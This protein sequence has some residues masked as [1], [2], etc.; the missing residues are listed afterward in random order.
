MVVCIILFFWILP[1]N[2]GQQHGM[3]E[4]TVKRLEVLATSTRDRVKHPPIPVF[5]IETSTYLLE[6]VLLENRYLAMLPVA[7]SVAANDTSPSLELF[8]GEEISMYLHTCNVIRGTMS[9]P[10]QAKTAN[11][12]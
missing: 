7:A 6:R 11:Y 3:N 9:I 1:N 4:T 2:L 12:R 5:Y 10:Y 8:R